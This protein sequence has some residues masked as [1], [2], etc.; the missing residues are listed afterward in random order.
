MKKTGLVIVGVIAGLV[1]IAN[2]GPLVGLAISLVI[3]YYA[4]KGFMGTTSVMKKILWASLGGI[5]LLS[6]VSNFPAI[7]TVIAA[8]VLYLVMKKWKT[9][10][11][12]NSNDNVESDPFINFEK[13]WQDLQKN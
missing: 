9:Q 6:A 13:Q 7:L 11:V 4:F 1:L 2:L 10:E 8:F 3:T 5:A 12:V